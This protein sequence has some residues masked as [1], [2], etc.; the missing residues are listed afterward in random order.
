MIPNVFLPGIFNEDGLAL[1][2]ATRRLICVDCW[3]QVHKTQ[4]KVS[5]V[6]KGDAGYVYLS[7]C[8]HVLCRCACHDP[9]IKKV[10]RDKNA[11][12]DIGE[13]FGYIT[14]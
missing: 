14:I 11:T 12:Q 6:K 10:L 4:V 13:V 3:N 5:V 8:M 7:K 9:K 2:P 1:D